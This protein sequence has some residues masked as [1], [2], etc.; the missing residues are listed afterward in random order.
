MP[1]ELF[2]A[3]TLI[4]GHPDVQ[5]DLLAD[6][7][8]DA[9]LS[10]DPTAHCDVAVSFS[11]GSL[12]LAGIYP[13][14]IDVVPLV[15]N[16]FPEATP[17]L[18]LV[19][20]DHN[21]GGHVVACGYAIDEPGTNDLPAEFWLARHLALRLESIATGGELI[22]LLE[23]E[24]RP[25][26]LAGCSISL[27]TSSL[28]PT[29]QRAVRAAL[30]EE[31]AHLAR[32]VPGFDSRLPESVAIQPFPLPSQGQSGGWLHAG[33]YGARI[34]LGDTSPC[35][36][37][38]AHPARALPILA[39]RLARA[40]VRTGVAQECRAVLTR[41]PGQDEAM[42]V[43]LHGD[44]KRLDPSRWGEL[45]DRSIPRFASRTT[46]KVTLA[47]VTHRGHFLSED[48]PWEQIRFDG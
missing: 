30:Q 22:V 20:G 11:P 38:L 35:G 33:A 8:V 44:G 17:R 39:R 6:A 9:A 46:G 31:L 23:S 42:I 27:G 32:R 1:L 19:P 13:Q 40:V 47:D 25:T 16:Y 36:K 29:L 15:G 45:V 43:S 37:D 41:V 28:T 7:L 48:W 34:P 12:T 3:H 2:A 14:A 18:Q 5:C 26:R 4:P 24:G 21:L 10:L